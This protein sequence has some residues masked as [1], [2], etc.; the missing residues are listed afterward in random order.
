MADRSNSFGPEAWIEGECRWFY[1]GT[2]P[3]E[4]PAVQRLAP[5][6]AQPLPERA[7]FPWRVGVIQ[8]LELQRDLSR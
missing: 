6:V 7:P 1:G 3:S 4:A 8:P 5:S 2:P